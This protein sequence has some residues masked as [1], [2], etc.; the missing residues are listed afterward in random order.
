MGF[1]ELIDTDAGLGEVGAESEEGSQAGEDS[2]PVIDP[3]IN[4]EVGAEE[5]G[6]GEANGGADTDPSVAER[7]EE[8]SFKDR[9]YALL[10]KGATSRTEQGQSG[11]EADKAVDPIAKELEDYWKGLVQLVE[12]GHIAR[13]DAELRYREQYRSEARLREAKELYE[14]ATTQATSSIIPSLFAQVEIKTGTPEYKEMAFVLKKEW[15]VDINDPR[16]VAKAGADNLRRF[17]KYTALE[18]KANAAKRGGGKPAG[19]KPAGA[20]SAGKPPAQRAKTPSD[21]YAGARSYSD[22]TRLAN[23]G[24]LK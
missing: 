5:T 16:S 2:A 18:V 21:A 10:E 4:A 9:Y 15:G 11:V 8:Q 7:R 12:D 23:E 24:K 14:K 22:I 6:E 17:V 19:G 1:E 20:A 3:E 13:Q